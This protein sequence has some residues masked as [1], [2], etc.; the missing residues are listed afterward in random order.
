MYRSA[1][2]YYQRA[3]GFDARHASVGLQEGPAKACWSPLGQ[4]YQ[5]PLGAAIPN[6]PAI[7]D[8][9]S[10]IPDLEWNPRD[11]IIDKAVPR[12]LEQFDGKPESYRLWRSRVRVHCISFNPAWARVTK[13]LE[14]YRYPMTYT[15]QQGINNVDG[16]YL[17]MR[18][19]G[20][21][22]WA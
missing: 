16:F 2:G 5:S 4:Q 19:L 9:A 20:Q 8:V 15:R 17:D 10:N 3:A 18:F 1:P 13:L 7:K 12:T 6:G 11:W 21:Q 22:L 14:T